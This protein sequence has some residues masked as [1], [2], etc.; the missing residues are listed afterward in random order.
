L[1]SCAAYSCFMFMKCCQKIVGRITV[2]AIPLARTA[3]SPA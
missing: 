3:S 1:S 2:L